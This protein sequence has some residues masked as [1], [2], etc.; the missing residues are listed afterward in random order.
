M[1]FL[2]FE[3]KFVDGGLDFTMRW[4]TRFLVSLAK[5]FGMFLRPFSIDEMI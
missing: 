2:R 1:A 3:G 4:D 5:S